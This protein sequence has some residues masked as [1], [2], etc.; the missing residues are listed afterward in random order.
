MRLCFSTVFAACVV[1]VAYGPD[2]AGP[3]VDEQ[4][5][6]EHLTSTAVRYLLGPAD[7]SDR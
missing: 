2:F 6:V 5:F 1:R 4:T 7:V 3:G